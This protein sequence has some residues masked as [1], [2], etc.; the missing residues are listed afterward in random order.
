MANVETPEVI[1]RRYVLAYTTPEGVK[2]MLSP[3]AYINGS[4]LLSTES[5]L[6]D[7]LKGWQYFRKAHSEKTQHKRPDSP[8]F[9][10]TGKNAKL[11]DMK[12]SELRDTLVDRIAST[13]REGAKTLWTAGGNE[14]VDG[15]KYYKRT[16]T[17]MVRRKANSRGS[18]NFRNV[19]IGNPL[20]SSNGYLLIN[21]ITCSCPNTFFEDGKE[22]AVETI[23]Y[24]AALLNIAFYHF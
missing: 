17:G 15:V 20:L 6:N 24:H 23:C 21:R 4:V 12:F 16:L 14:V 1:P 2:V 11:L 9:R 10:L 19:A 7:R 5:D 18:N 3:S 8:V 22:R 13:N